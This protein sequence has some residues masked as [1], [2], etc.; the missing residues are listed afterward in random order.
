MIGSATPPVKEVL[1]HEEN[2]FLVDFFDRDAIVG[3][4]VASLEEPRKVV[5]LRQLARQYVIER[6]D[7]ATRC[8][9]EMLRY[10]KQE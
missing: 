7:L 2:G 10:L 3:A 9:P 1:K 8:L 6:F 5:P 4:I